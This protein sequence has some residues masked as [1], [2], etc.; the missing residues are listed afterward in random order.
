MENT[1]QNANVVVSAKRLRYKL[2][3]GRQPDERQLIEKKPSRS[4]AKG[5]RLVQKPASVFFSTDWFAATLAEF[6]S[7]SS[8]PCAA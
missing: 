5:V 3:F 6:Q 7:S 1:M 8:K 4:A 2:L